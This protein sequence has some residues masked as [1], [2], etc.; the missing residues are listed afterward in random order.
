MGGGVYSGHLSRCCWGRWG[1]L[2]SCFILVLPFLMIICCRVDLVEEEEPKDAF[3]W[4]QLECDVRRYGVSNVVLN[5]SITLQLR[6]RFRGFLDDAGFPGWSKGNWVLRSAPS[7][8]DRCSQP[9]NLMRIWWL[10]L[11]WTEANQNQKAVHVLV[12]VGSYTGSG[13][14]CLALT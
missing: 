3:E 10:I 2:L 8:V 11:V 9:L 1:V 6:S 5:D 13:Y 14:L 7:L 4:W 12:K